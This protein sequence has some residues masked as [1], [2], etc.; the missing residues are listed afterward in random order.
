MGTNYRNL[1]ED[2]KFSSAIRI[3]SSATFASCLSDLTIFCVAS[4]ARDGGLTDEQATALADLM[5]RHG[6][7]SG[8]EKVNKKERP[9]EALSVWQARLERIDWDAAVENFDLFQSSA[10]D[11]MR[12]APVIDEFKEQDSENVQN[13]IHLRWKDIRNQWRK[14]AV[15]ATIAEEWRGRD[16]A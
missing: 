7:K 4:I 9:K 10:D 5:Y 16:A 14:R 8:L 11:L 12:F 15:A 13:N 2:E 6:F 3:A 1:F